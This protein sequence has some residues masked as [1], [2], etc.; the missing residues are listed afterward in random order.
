[1][2]WLVG[3][4]G[5]LVATTPALGAPSAS[6]P[7]G[8]RLRSP[9]EIRAAL[10]NRAVVLCGC[11]DAAVKHDARLSGKFVYS[12]T[13]GKDGTARRVRAVAPTKQSHAL[14]ECIVRVIRRV[15]FARSED[16]TSITYPI[17]F[18]PR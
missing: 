16:E 4:L 14:D 9:H 3:G 6:P 13:I 1:M 17:V 2:R 10:E 18:Q 5:F 7:S 11:Y 8:S 15:K 12:F